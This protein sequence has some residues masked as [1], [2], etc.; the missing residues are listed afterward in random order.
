MIIIF[1]FQIV[2]YL[3]LTSNFEL[4]AALPVFSLS[5]L[6][7]TSRYAECRRPSSST[8]FSSLLSLTSPREALVGVGCL[9]PW[10]VFTGVVPRA[11]RESL[12][13]A[14]SAVL[15]ALHGLPLPVGGGPP[16][17]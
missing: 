7:P 2:I 16:P 13:G 6:S 1:T 10:G 11:S 14:G 17:L 5:L 15:D 8:L 3:H 4:R 9:R 12:T